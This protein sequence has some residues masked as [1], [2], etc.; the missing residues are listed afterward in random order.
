MMLTVLLTIGAA[1]LFP[2]ALKLAVEPEGR[3]KWLKSL[4]GL[5]THDGPSQPNTSDILGATAIAPR[6]SF[7]KHALWIYGVIVGLAIREALSATYN[8]PNSS[9]SLEVTFSS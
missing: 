8:H 5:A 3:R 7:G 9:R 2:V 6:M 1:V 4:F